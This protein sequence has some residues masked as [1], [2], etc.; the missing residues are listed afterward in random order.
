MKSFYSNGRPTA[1]FF[2]NLLIDWPLLLSTAVEP[3][4]GVLQTGGRGAAL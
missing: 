3:I 2:A 1:R 4:A